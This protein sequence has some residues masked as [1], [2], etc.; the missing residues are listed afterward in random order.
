MASILGLYRSFVDGLLSVAGRR[1]SRSRRGDPAAL[2]S[3]PGA[4]RAD[5]DRKTLSGFLT[6]FLA[7][8]L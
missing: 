1:Y 7:N 8:A 2:D 6:G 3:V 5:T 4:V